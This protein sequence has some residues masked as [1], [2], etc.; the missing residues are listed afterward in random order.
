MVEDD[1]PAAEEVLELHLQETLR[2]LIQVN[3]ITKQI[4]GIVL[5]GGDSESSLHISVNALTHT[6]FFALC[7]ACMLIASMY[8]CC[9]ILP[10]F[11]LAGN[12]QNGSEG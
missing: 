8:Q 2:E 9:L 11:K 10:N 7:Q 4:T 6:V 3:H 12:A 5:K 1:D